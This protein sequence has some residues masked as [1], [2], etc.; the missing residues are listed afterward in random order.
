[1]RKKKKK[2]LNFAGS[3]IQN[4]SQSLPPEDSEGE[5]FSQSPTSHCL[6]TMF[7]GVPSPALSHFRGGLGLARDWS[8]SH[9]RI[10]R[11]KYEYTGCG[12]RWNGRGR[13]DKAESGAK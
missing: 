7:R 12:S 1:M 2:R 3:L 8:A 13:K 9:N 6:R 5:A 10:S 4:A 11:P